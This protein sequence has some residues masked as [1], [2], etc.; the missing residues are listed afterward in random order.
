MD[1]T[2]LVDD[3]PGTTFRLRLAAAPNTA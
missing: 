3:G 2:L 1:A